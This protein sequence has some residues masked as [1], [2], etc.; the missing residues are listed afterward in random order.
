MKLTRVSVLTALA[1]SLSST[2]AYAAPHNRNSETLAQRQTNGNSNPEFISQRGP[3]MGQRDGGQ[4]WL[5]QLN[6]STE[7]QQQ[8]QA[9]RDRYQPQMDAN[10]EQMRQTMDEMRQLMT[11]NASDRDLRNKHNELVQL[12]QQISE[13]HFEQMLAI[14]NVLTPEQRQQFAQQMQERR[15]NW[16]NNRGN[17]PGNRGGANQGGGNGSFPDD[18]DF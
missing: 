18:D 7:Q 6:L 15:E 9:I 16:Q 17:R 1:I 12:R 13:I 8:I 10:K 14:R 3:G 4:R 2:A 5:Q 11:G